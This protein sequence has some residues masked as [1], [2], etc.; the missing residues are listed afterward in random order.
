[1]PTCTLFYRFAYPIGSDRPC[2]VGDTFCEL[3]T[4]AE[5]EL[6]RLDGIVDRVVDTIPQFEVSVGAYTFTGSSRIVAFDTVGVDT[7]DMVDLTSDPFSFPINRLGRWFLYFRV[8]TNG[9]NATQL[10]IPVSVNNTP[11]LG[12]IVIVQDYQDDGTNYPVPIQGSGYNR[13]PV[14]GHRVSLSVSTAAL[15]IVSAT[16]GGYWMGDL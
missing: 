6:D 9:D 15:T 16:F 3:V 14:A 1:M 5:V 8:I 2:D 11:S 12:S 13:Y 10:N 4:A 7:D